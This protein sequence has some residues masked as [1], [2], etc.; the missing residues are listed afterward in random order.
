MN[1][2]VIYKTLTY[3]FQYFVQKAGLPPGTR[4]Q[5]KD[6]IYV[7]Q[8]DGSWVKEGKEEKEF[9][10]PRDLTQMTSQ[11]NRE[12]VDYLKDRYSEKQLDKRVNLIDLQI[13][14]R[15]E[16]LSNQGIDFRKVKDHG[17]NNLWH[18]RK[19]HETAIEE[20]RGK[21]IK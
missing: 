20:I 15:E 18:N 16:E 3:L 11:Q 6:G 12:V 14:R 7:K 21:R 10:L 4:R 5:R 8:P 17:L 13:K 1:R 19:L 9:D 2:N